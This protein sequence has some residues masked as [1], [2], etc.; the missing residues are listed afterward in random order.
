MPD[1]AAAA[2]QP[3]GS[4]Q[5]AQKQRSQYSEMYQSISLLCVVVSYCTIKV[6]MDNII[7]GLDLPWLADSRGVKEADVS[8]IHCKLERARHGRLRLHVIVRI[9][10]LRSFLSVA[11]S[12]SSGCSG[13]GRVSGWWRRTVEAVDHCERIPRVESQPMGTWNDRCRLHTAQHS[14]DERE[15]DS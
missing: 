10:M 3:S 4:S 1:P 14:T 15:T 8:S 2:A 5:T 12:G 7:L 13:G 6:C 9:H 11:R